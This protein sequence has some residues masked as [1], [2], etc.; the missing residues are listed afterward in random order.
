MKKSI[1]LGLGS[2]LFIIGCA[3]KPLAKNVVELAGNM[4]VVGWSGKGEKIKK[5]PEKPTPHVEVEN[6]NYVLPPDSD[7]DGVP[8]VLDRCP[9]TPENLTVNHYGCPILTT[10][11]INFDL[12]KWKV[13]K[14]YYPQLQKVAEVMKANPKLNIEVD[15][16]TDDLGNPK[17]NLWLSKKRAEAVRDV[18]VKH[19]GI[20]PRR[21][22]A[23]GFGEKFPL[24]PNTN[25]TNRCINR[26]V[27][28]VN[29]SEV[30]V[31]PIDT[32]NKTSN[33]ASSIQ[34]AESLK[35]VAYP[36][37]VLNSQIPYNMNEKVS[38]PKTQKPI[39]LP[40]STTQPGVKVESFDNVSIDEILSKTQTELQKEAP[41]EKPSLV[42]KST[43]DKEEV[44]Q[45][46][47]N[48]AEVNTN[49]S[50]QTTNS[51]QSSPVKK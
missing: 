47:D 16:Y 29:T 4:K 24:V 51:Q 30:N 2:L 28:I 18:L 7:G 22:V 11:R 50:K 37:S 36:K 6:P 13:K 40:I 42:V 35:P 19:F 39:N 33:E 43:T 34:K 48:F 9:N 20:S 12:G 21:I 27:E 10:L 25:E 46:N 44:V 17:Y 41:K 3:E 26:R 49:S 15:G 38:T 14:I 1:I 8:D 45:M 5:E 32:T 31:A 23:K